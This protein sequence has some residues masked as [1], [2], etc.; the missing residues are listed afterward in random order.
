MYKTATAYNCSSASFS[1][2]LLSHLPHPDIDNFIDLSTTASPKRAGPQTSILYLILCL[3]LCCCFCYVCV[4]Q[5]FRTSRC[6]VKL[7]PTSVVREKRAYWLRPPPWAV[8]WR[9]KISQPSL[10]CALSKVLVIKFQAHKMY[11]PPS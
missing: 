8:G 3:Y 1:G 2:G 6:L 7:F 5:L 11:K 4:C 9:L 10:N